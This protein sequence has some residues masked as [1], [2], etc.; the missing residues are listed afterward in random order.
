MDLLAR[1][2]NNLTDARYF[3]AHLP[4]WISLN[5]PDDHEATIQKLAEIQ[6][7]IEGVQWA[8][9]LTDIKVEVAKLQSYLSLQGVILYEAE[10]CFKIDP[11]LKR[12]LVANDQED[13]AELVYR[14]IIDG[15][16]LHTDN[17]SKNL[18]Y[19]DNVACWLQINITDD[20][21]V[22]NDLSERLSGIVIAGGPEERVGFKSYEQ[23]D[24]LLDQYDF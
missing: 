5:V 22:A 6:S 4:A 2:I 19:V 18:Q 7:W 9:E 17:L 11:N 13:I 14:G 12:F 23:I 10:Q 3:A 20:W 8:V 16:I 15:L 1:N 21:K 24:E